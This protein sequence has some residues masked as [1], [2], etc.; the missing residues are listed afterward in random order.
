MTSAVSSNAQKMF[1]SPVF[2]NTNT[3]NSASALTKHIEARIVRYVFI[4]INCFALQKYILSLILQ[5][6]LPVIFHEAV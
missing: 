2:M 3:K 4:Y 1:L 6:N 5:N